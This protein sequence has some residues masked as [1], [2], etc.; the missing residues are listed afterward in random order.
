MG[1]TGCDVHSM[2]C[3]FAQEFM[4]L[5]WKWVS[6]SNSILSGVLCRHKMCFSRPEMVSWAVAVVYRVCCQ[7]ASCCLSRGE[8]VTLASVPWCVHGTGAVCQASPYWEPSCCPLFQGKFT[9][10]AWLIA[11]HASHSWI[12]SVQWPPWSGPPLDDEPI[13]LLQLMMH[14]PFRL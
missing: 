13:C 7:P 8:Y 9:L 10:L 3:F 11:A 14:S 1:D 12:H 6:L 5:F 2:P 4:T